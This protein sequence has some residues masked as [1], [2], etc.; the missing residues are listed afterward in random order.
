[1]AS[2]EYDLRYLQSGLLDLQGYLLSKELY[3]PIG[4]SSPAG[5][6]PYPRM[7]LGNLLLSEARLNAQS[8]SPNQ[9][10][11]FARLQERLESSRSEW[12]VAW[13]QKAQREFSARLSLWRDFIEEYRR[14][15]QAN[16]DRYSYE[17][18]RRV[19]LDLLQPVAESIPPEEQELLGGLDQVLRAVL[20]RGEFVWDDEL[21]QGFPEN[22]YWYLYGTPKSED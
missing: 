12:R 21:R 8:L 18:T 11:E 7:T 17:V 15:P 20:V 2:P 4:A 10:E 6:A 5:E 16:V 3:W 22:Q 13:S 14:K 9:K 1:M 19:L